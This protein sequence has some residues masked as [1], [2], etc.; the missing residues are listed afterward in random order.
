MDHQELTQRYRQF[1]LA[2]ARRAYK[3]RSSRDFE[4][5]LFVPTVQ[6]R[7]EEEKALTGLLEQAR[8][9]PAPDPV[10]RLLKSHFC[11]FLQG[12][13]SA[14][15]SLGKR[16]SLS[17]GGL[18]GFIDF[19]ARKDSRSDEQRLSI[20]NTRLEQVDGL[21]AGLSS[22]L[23]QA[24]GTA[25][26]Q[27][28]DAAG[29]LTRVARLLADGIQNY[30]PAIS[31][32]GRQALAGKLYALADKAGEWQKDAAAL[33]KPAEQ[34]GGNASLQLDEGYYR[35][36]LLEQLG[37]ELDELVQWHQAEV[38]KNREEVFAIAASLD[39]P[40]KAATMEGVA[41]VLAKYAG[42]CA[43]PDEM[44]ARGR[45]YL[46]RARRGAEGYV[47]LPEEQ[48]LVLPVPEQIKGH[49]PW[50]GYGGGC[51]RRRPLAGE[52]YLNEGNYRAVTDGW[53]KMMAIHEAYPGHHVQFVR[54]AA[55]P[56]PE[57]VKL[58]A[59]SI[60]LIEG[61]AHRSERV[62]EFVFAE[63]PFYPLFVAYRR[64]HTA[65]RIMAELYLRYFGRPL[66]EAVDLY[67]RELGFDRATARGQVRAQE[68]MV[69]Y[70]NCYY[71]GLKRLLDLEKK[72]GIGEKAYTEMLFSVG[73]ISLQ[74]FE[75]FLALDDSDKKRF[76]TQF[77]SLLED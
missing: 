69:G 59:R 61:A 32:Q 33:A 65:V 2:C 51:H 62:F 44:F 10:Y 71:Y 64:H 34:S 48:C 11:Q 9:L 75:A 23:G 60:P 45:E 25:I 5:Q 68:L 74:S 49:F 24:D 8:A 20:V 72:H 58:G 31:R 28:V 35:H 26:S 18:T 22:E 3:L 56:L 40:E 15:D 41:A 14:L 76:Q 37:V 43:T 52:M 16:P 36:L 1:D 46:E 47:S 66:N 6:S 13:I 21:W 54:S 30:F 19:V 4:G 53:L 17:I 70:F 29:I 39:I 50:G 63:D 7:A 12:Q 38:E 27:L 67:V 77:P 55:D 57:T 42:C 73:R